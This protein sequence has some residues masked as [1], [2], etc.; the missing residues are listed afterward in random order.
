[1]IVKYQEYNPYTY[2]KRTGR[3]QITTAQEDSVMRRMVVRSPTSLMKK[4]RAKLLY[5][6]CQVSHMIVFRSLSKKINLKSYKLAKKS[7]LNAAMK[8]KHLQFA[9]SQQHW[10]AQQ[11]RKVLFCDESTFQQFVVQK[12]HICRPLKNVLITDTQYQQ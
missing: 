9:N 2:Q 3:P 8:A 1:M 5:R 7:R 4:I 12:W 11:C 6:G 10:T